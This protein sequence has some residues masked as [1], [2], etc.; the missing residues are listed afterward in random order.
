MSTMRFNAL[1]SV[2]TTLNRSD[3]SDQT[4]AESIVLPDYILM[5]IRFIC[6]FMISRANKLWINKL[7]KKLVRALSNQ[8]IDDTS[9]KSWVSMLI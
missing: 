6:M 4:F 8:A 1:E 2:Y 7:Y 5:T 3:L 9:S